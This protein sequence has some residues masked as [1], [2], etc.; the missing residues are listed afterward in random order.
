MSLAGSVLAWYLPGGQVG[1]LA[2]RS[3]SRQP[4]ASQVSAASVAGT[5]AARCGAG[6]GAL[7]QCAGGGVRTMLRYVRLHRGGCVL[8]GPGIAGCGRDTCTVQPG[9][10]LRPRTRLTGAR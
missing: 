1:D 10:R 8:C 5:L 3:D 4:G 9:M 6:E 2:L 7:R